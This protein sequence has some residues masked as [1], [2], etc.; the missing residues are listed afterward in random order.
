MFVISSK[1]MICLLWDYYEAQSKW[2]NWPTLN[3]DGQKQEYFYMLFFFG[4]S[5]EQK[6]LLFNMALLECDSL[7][8]SV[9]TCHAGDPGSKAA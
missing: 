4:P 3:A 1:I 8:I 9:L 7:T 2:K 5:R 6:V